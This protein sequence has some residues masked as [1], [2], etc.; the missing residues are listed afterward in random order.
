MSKRRKVRTGQR[1]TT[2]RTGGKRRSKFQAW[3]LSNGKSSRV[4]VKRLDAD[5]TDS[6]T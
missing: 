4:V 1:A 6:G 2:A 3:R 5:G